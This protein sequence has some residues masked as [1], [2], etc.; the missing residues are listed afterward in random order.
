M[1]SETKNVFVR[2][3]AESI[4]E[5]FFVLRYNG[6]EASVPIEAPDGL[7]YTICLEGPQFDQL[8]CCWK[9]R[10]ALTSNPARWPDHPTYDS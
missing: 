8:I 1:A 6:L 9:D 10:V 7:C 2:G 3:V 4:C 5:L